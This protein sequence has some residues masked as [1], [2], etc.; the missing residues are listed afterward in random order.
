[1]HLGS[2]IH[3]VALAD[4]IRCRH[5]RRGKRIHADEIGEAGFLFE[6][7]YMHARMEDEL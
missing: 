6:P 1:M 2:Q 7:A 3:D 5:L 4:R